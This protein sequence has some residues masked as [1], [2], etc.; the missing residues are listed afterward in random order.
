MEKLNDNDTENR[1][2]TIT[3]K[4]RSNFK[5]KQFF[6]NYFL[7]L[8]KMGLFQALVDQNFLKPKS[9]KNTRKTHAHTGTKPLAM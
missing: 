7:K 1:N 8:K 9:D 4:E 5:Q 6:P 2:K 3:P